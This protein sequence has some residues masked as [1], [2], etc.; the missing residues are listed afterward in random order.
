MLCAASTMDCVAGTP[1][2]G[3]PPWFEALD[4]NRDGQVSLREWLAGGQKLEDFPRHD[5][6]DD[7][8][9]TAEEV[10]GPGKNGSHLKLVKGQVSYQGAIDEV[11]NEG[12]QRKKSYKIFTIRLEGGRTYQFEQVSQVYFA[13]L[14]LE[15]PNGRILDS[16]D[17][18]GNGR[19]ARIVHRAAETGTYRLIATSQGGF[20]TGAFSL[21]VRVLGAPRGTLPNGLP[22]WFEVLDTN[23]E[24]QVSLREW[25]ASGKTLKDF[26]TFDLNDDGLITV[27]ELVPRGEKRLHLKIEKGQ[28]NYTGT[29]G[30]PTD[31]QY[32]SKRLARILTLRLE[33][34]KTYQIDHKSRAFDAYLYLERSDGGVLARDDDGG[35]NLNARIVHR[36][37]ETGTYRLIV[38]SLNGN[39]VGAFSLSVRVLGGSSG[40]AR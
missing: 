17:S 1:P 22:P 16:N 32:R 27:E 19:T 40:S 13:F 5:R 7:G 25:L 10:L 34:G 38:T 12:Y 8:L 35:G 21:S 33:A 30:E 29:L 4:T 31:D 2:N 23:R 3:L 24:G 20:R 6:N 28:A 26:R 15:G 39:G 11:P 14:Y 37:T 9:I 36:A 18:G